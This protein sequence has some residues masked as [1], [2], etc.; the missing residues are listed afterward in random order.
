VPVLLVAIMGGLTLIY[1]AKMRWTVPSILIALGLWGWAF[2]GIAGVL[3]TAIPVNQVTHNTLRM[4]A[5]F[6]TYYLLGVLAFSFAYLYY[7][8]NERSGGRESFVSR[9]AAWLYGIGGAG[10]VLMFML[11]GSMSVPR[12]FAQHIPAWQ[13]PDQIS[14][15][16]VGLISLAL[17]WLGSEI[18]LRLGRAWRGIDAHP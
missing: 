1:R 7:L 3:D 14:V 18:F 4:P 8:V 6:H 2:G 17:L 11:S 16:F 15:G 12:R 13:L 5:H 10:F 9:A